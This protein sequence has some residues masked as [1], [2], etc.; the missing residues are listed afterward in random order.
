MAPR[1]R[2]LAILSEDPTSGPRTHTWQLI[3]AYNSRLGESNSSLV[4]A[5][6]GKHA[7]TQIDIIKM[8]KSLKSEIESWLRV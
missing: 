4:S 5:V 7:H 2:T 1:L 6:S 3:T 8:N